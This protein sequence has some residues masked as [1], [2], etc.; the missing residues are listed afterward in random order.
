MALL[1][2]HGDIPIIHFLG[3]IKMLFDTIVDIKNITAICNKCKG[4]GTIR[5]PRDIKFEPILIKS[6]GYP[7]DRNYHTILC[8]KCV[9]NGYVYPYKLFCA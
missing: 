2:N 4:K 3:E 8:P 6:S 1:M 7:N 5:V 9:G